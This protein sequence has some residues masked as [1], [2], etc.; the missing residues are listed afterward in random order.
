MFVFGHAG[1]TVLG[2]APLH[3][4]F[5][6]NTLW[7]RPTVLLTIACLALLPD[8]IDKPMAFWVLHDPPSTRLVAHTL[9]FWMVVGAFLWFY[10]RAWVWYVLAPLFHLVLDGMWNS[11]HTLFFPLLGWQMDLGDMNELSFWEFFFR[12]LRVTLVHWQ[13]LLPELAGCA[14]L[15]YAALRCIFQVRAV[16]RLRSA[17]NTPAVNPPKKHKTS[18]R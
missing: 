5:K 1:L 17:V 16:V 13:H 18:L 14:V 8:I 6:H 7:N 9:I 2:M 11:P 4:H 12:D 3:S 15:I 10:K